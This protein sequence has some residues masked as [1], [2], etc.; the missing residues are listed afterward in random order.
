MIDRR[1]FLGTTRGASA[2]ICRPNPSKGMLRETKTLCLP[3]TPEGTV[4]LPEMLGGVR[5]VPS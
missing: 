5:V 4:K 1:H 3:D 2:V